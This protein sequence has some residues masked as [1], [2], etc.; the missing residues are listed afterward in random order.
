MLKFFSRI[1]ILS[2]DAKVGRTSAATDHVKFRIETIADFGDM[3]Y[4]VLRYR[5]TLTKGAIVEKNIRKHIAWD[6]RSTF[7][8]APAGYRPSRSSS[9]RAKPYP[10]SDFGQV[11]T[12][13]F[14]ESRA[15]GRSRCNKCH[16]P[17]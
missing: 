15:L 16:S 7:E 8:N 5:L 13:F 4:G 12:A 11:S 10:D 6:R 17:T 14:S 9:A 3:R 1:D 2:D